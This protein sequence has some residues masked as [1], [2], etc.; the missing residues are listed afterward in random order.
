MFYLCTAAVSVGVSVQVSI[1][2]SIDVS[3]AVSFSYNYFSRKIQNKSQ[4]ALRHNSPILQ[5]VIVFEIPPQY[6]SL[7][8]ARYIFAIAVVELIVNSTN[9]MPSNRVIK[10]TSVEPRTQ[11]HGEIVAVA[12]VPIN[13]AETPCKFYYLFIHCSRFIVAQFIN[14]TSE[15]ISIS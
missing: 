1:E 3:V 12:V 7:W 4:H 9:E 2:V 14:I 13:V 8:I 10:Y 11:H 6:H 5:F 15:Q